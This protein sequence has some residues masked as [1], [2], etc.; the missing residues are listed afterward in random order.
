MK[1]LGTLVLASLSGI[2][3]TAAP[4][5]CTSGSLAS[6]LALSLDGCTVGGLQFKDFTLLPVDA[7]ATAIAPADVTINPSLMG[8][9]STLDVV[10]GVSVVADEVLN[11]VFGYLVMPVNSSQSIISAGLN[12][13]PATAL[14]TGVALAFQD[15]CASG[16]FMGGMCTGAASNQAVFQVDGEQDLAKMTSFN[17]GIGGLKVEFDVIADGGPAGSATLSSASNSF[18]AT[19]EPATPSLVALV[20]GMLFIARRK[21]K[22]TVR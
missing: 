1:L 9:T 5:A 22:G 21:M 14:G 4:V 13:G 6:Y 19:P 18:T 10:L 8:L 15:L 11:I 17:P 20:S 7:S 3:L 12:L 2:G 16:T